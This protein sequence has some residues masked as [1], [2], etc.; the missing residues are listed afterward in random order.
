MPIIQMRK[1]GVERRGWETCSRS[2]LGQGGRES[3]M[4]LK[5]VWWPHKPLCGDHQR[6]I[7]QSRTDEHFPL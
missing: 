2:Q 7:S 4:A 6:G 3:S 5:P 1:S